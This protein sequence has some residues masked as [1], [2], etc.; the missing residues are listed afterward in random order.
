[1]KNI[2]ILLLTILLISS[3]GF[4]C[5]KVSADSGSGSVIVNVIYP[6]TVYK[7]GNGSGTVTGTGINCGSDCSETYSYGTIVTLTATAAT[8]SSFAGWSGNCDSTGKVSMTAG[9]TCFATFNNDYPTIDSVTINTSSINANSSNQYTITTKASDSSGAANVIRE[10]AIINYQGDNAG[11]YRGYLTWAIDADHWPSLKN[12]MACSGGGWAAIQPGYGDTYLNLI[13]C[14]VSSSGNQRTVNFV[15]TFDPSFTSPSDNDIS[16]YPYDNLGQ[17]NGWVNF[18]TSFSVLLPTCTSAGPDIDTTTAT[19]GTR[20]TYVYGA[21]NV[22]NVKFP[23]WS[24]VNGQDDIVWY[25]GVNDGGGTWHADANLASHPGLGY[26]THT[27]NA[28][29]R[30]KGSTPVFC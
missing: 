22:T 19:T 6:L 7:D 12:H 17:T 25:N 30:L 10:Y 5:N 15:V 16:G 8:G 21:T 26:F 9:K 18:Q 2:K 24:E 20:R 11:A 13:S 23:T 1:M 14:S 27:Q 28:Y 29:K 3:V 4:V